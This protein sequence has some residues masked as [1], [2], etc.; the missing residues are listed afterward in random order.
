MIAQP[1]T[2]LKHIA[3][4]EVVISAQATGFDVDAFVRR[5][6]TDTSFHKAFLNTRFHPH[7]VRS[8][9]R[10]RR[11][12]EREAATLYRRGR[13][14]REGR[15]AQLAIDSLAEHGRLRDRKGGFRYLTVEMYDDVFFPKG[16]FPADNTVAGRKLVVER[17]SRFEK[18]KGELKK[19]MFDPGTEIASVPFIGDKLA[20]F[21]PE[22]APLYDFR[23][24]SDMKGDRPCWV[25]SADAKPEFRDGRTVIKTMDTWF[26]R[27]TNEVLARTYRIAHASIFLDFDIRINVRNVSLHGQLVPVRVDYDGDWDI[28]FQQ[29]ELV[30]FWLEYTN[31]EVA[32]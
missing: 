7:H 18:Y 3:L 5:V 14:I 25:F 19:F 24:W 27:E 2:L 32:Y 23:I 13:L 28:P 26:D 21:S 9:V 17:G 16:T 31:W 12:D 20:L 30:R 15:N 4:D 10:V 6:R 29:R 1:D 22:M 8:E 11:K